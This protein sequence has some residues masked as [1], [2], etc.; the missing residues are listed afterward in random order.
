MADGRHDG[1]A[2]LSEPRMNLS[3]QECRRGISGKGRQE[4]ERNHSIC[5]SVVLFERRNE[6]SYGGIV[7]ARDDEAEK[8]KSQAGH[9][10]TRRIPALDRRRRRYGRR[11]IGTDVVVVI[12]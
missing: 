2:S 3:I 7:H 4:D 9:V 1:D 6:G 12:I 11:D 5:E 10:A 8:G